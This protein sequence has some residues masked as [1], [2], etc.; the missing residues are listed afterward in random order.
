VYL[1]PTVPGKGLTVEALGFILLQ[2]IIGA[3]D[4][5]FN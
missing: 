2:P 5:D 1:Y 3:D 4:M